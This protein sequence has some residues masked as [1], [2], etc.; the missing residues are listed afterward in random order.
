M[1]VRG[2]AQVAE[3]ALVPVLD[4]RAADHLG[5]HEARAEPASLAAERLHADARHRRQDEPRRDLDGPDRPGL[6]KIE[7]R[8][9]W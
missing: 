3:G 6:A 5:A 8:L 9:E 4:S 2:D 7:H 1:L